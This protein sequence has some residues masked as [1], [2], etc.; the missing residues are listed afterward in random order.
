MKKLLLV[1]DYQYDFV[2]D[3][4]KLTAGRPAQLI[5]P[6]ILSRIAAFQTAGG[7]VICTQ[8]THSSQGWKKATRNLPPSRSTVKKGPPAGP[9][10]AA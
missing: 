9:S 7:D 3:A 10:T 6:A 4:G 1:I 8:D 5:E 2:A